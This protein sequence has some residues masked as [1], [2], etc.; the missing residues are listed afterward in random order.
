MV[1]KLI[2]LLHIIITLDQQKGSLAYLKVA[3]VCARKSDHALSI[4]FSIK[5][6]ITIPV[7]RLGNRSYIFGT[8]STKH[9]ISYIMQIAIII[10]CI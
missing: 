2:A 8:M 7:L 10:Q 3:I 4:F 1:E 5:D 6:F 9:V